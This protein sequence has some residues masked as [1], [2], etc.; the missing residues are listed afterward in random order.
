MRFFF[1][2]VAD[3][4]KLKIF[5]NDHISSNCVRINKIDS[6]MLNGLLIRGIWNIQGVSSLKSVFK[7]EWNRTWK[8]ENGSH[9]WARNC[10]FSSSSISLAFMLDPQL[11]LRD[12]G[13]GISWIVS[14]HRLDIDPGG[15]GLI[16]CLFSWEVF[17]IPWVSWWVCFPCVF[18]R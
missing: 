5:F 2:Y 17:L 11:K 3:R 15:L 7:H 8:V 9:L 18:C 6:V 12:V 4:P 14:R 13:K 10:H 16:R 1:S